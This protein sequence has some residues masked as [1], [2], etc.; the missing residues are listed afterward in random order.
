M[1]KKTLFVNDNGTDRPMTLEEI[2]EYE[3]NNL[4]IQE[5]R[6]KEANIESLRASRKEKLIA[7]GLTE[8]EL[9]A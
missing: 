9:E 7:L 3:A 4:F 6:T 2:A 8:E 5:L 1:A